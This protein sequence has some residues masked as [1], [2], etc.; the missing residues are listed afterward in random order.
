M[1]AFASRS[2]MA[3]FSG[4]SIF[5]DPGPVAHRGGAFSCLDFAAATVA[6][7]PSTRQPARSPITPPLTSFSASS[8]PAMPALN[9]RRN[10]APR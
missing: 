7:L 9:M 8:T 1:L 3:Y 5:P 2:R 4:R 10:S 6:P